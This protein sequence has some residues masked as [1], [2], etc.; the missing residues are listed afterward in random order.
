LNHQVFEESRKLFFNSKVSIMKFLTLFSK[1][2]VVS[3]FIWAFSTTPQPSKIDYKGSFLSLQT[4]KKLPKMDR[5][6]L[7]GLH[8]YEMTKDLQL[9]YPPTERKL[10]AYEELKSRKTRRSLDLRAIPNTTWQE[11]GPNNVGG[12]TRAIM[13]DPNDPEGKRVFAGGVSG[14]LWMNPNIEDVNS[15]WENKDDFMASLAVSSLAF[16]PTTPT[17]FYLATGEGWSHQGLMRGNGIWKSLDGGESWGHLTGTKGTEFTFVNRIAVTA[18]GHIL[19]ATNHGLQ[20]SIDGGATWEVKVPGRA[21]DIAIATNGTIYISVG[22]FSPG[23]IFRS[24]DN[25]QSFQEL[26]GYPT[27]GQRI[28]LAVAPSNPNTLYAV[29]SSNGNIAWFRKSTDGGATWTP[30]AVPRYLNQN[31][32]QSAQDFGR[33]QAWYNLALAVHPENENRVVLGGIDLYKSENGGASWTPIS[34]WTG[35]CKTYVHAD[36]HAIVFHPTRFE[37][38]L[39]GND[40][41]VYRSSDIGTPTESPKFEVRNNGYN[42]TQFYSVAMANSEG[43]HYFLGGTQDNGT[44][45]FASQGV[46]T[47]KMVTGGDGGL[48]FIDQEDPSIQ[49]TSYVYNSY[50][51]STNGGAFFVNRFVDESN[52]GTG[53]FINP[54]DYDSKAKT[55]YAAR[56]ENQMAR[57]SNMAGTRVVNEVLT[58]A[59]GNRR[60]THVKVNPFSPNSLIVANDIG[61]VYKISD[62]HA[63]PIVERIDNHALPAGYVSSVDIGEHEGQLLVTLSNYGVVS[64]WETQNGGLSWDNKEGN[65]PDIPVRW[66]LYNPRNI[67]QVLLATELGIW[68]TDDFSVQSP[69]WEPTLDGLA[70]VRCD[71]LR[72][73]A[74]DGMVAVATHGR[75]LYTTDVFAHQFKADFSVDKTLAYAEQ[76]FYFNDLSFGSEKSWQWEFGDGTTSQEQNPTHH[77]TIAGTYTVKLTIRQGAASVVKEHLIQVLPIKSLDYLT[78]QGGNFEVNTTDF[79]AYTI[80]GTAFQRG[81]SIFPGKSGTTSGQYAWVTGLQGRYAPRTHAMVYTPAFQVNTSGTYQVEFKAIYHLEVEDEQK[82]WDGFVVEYTFDLGNTWNKLGNDLSENWYNYQAHGHNT[83]F[84]SGEAMFSGNTEGEFETKRTQFSIPDQ[85]K[86]VAFRVVFKSDANGEEAGLAIDD[87]QFTLLNANIPVMARI[88]TE[89]PDCNTSEVLFTSHSFGNLKEMRWT[90]GP[91]THLPSL[92]GNGPHKVS[93]TSSGVK[94]ATLWVTDG[95]YTH[96]STLSI[97]VTA[98]RLT[99]VGEELHAS[100]GEAYTWYRNGE[101]I[102]GLH[103]DRLHLSGREE[104]G[105]FQ[106]AVTQAGCTQKSEIITI[107]DEIHI[108]TFPNPTKGMVQIEAR[109]QNGDIKL[110]RVVDRNGR[111][112]Q[113]IHT[114]SFAGIQIDFSNEPKGYY[115]VELNTSQGTITR[116]ILKD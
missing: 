57:Y 71:M 91:D 22:V 105:Y 70:N 51:R 83:A 5:P 66:A 30:L 109:G 101:I 19:A 24:S 11:R 68:S 88:H 35:L 45:Q 21:A 62:A 74:A 16:D 67:R 7:A 113:V 96:E 37:E 48:T 112:V 92:H 40:G 8:D 103:S 29:A 18:L 12:R 38:A 3:L 2:L 55:L 65:L 54:A 73:R 20:I 27:N 10:A 9:G 72:Y 56:N 59:I 100:G 61:Q 63:T 79:A 97:V 85:V 110:S 1:V 28:E 46:N 13:F 23:R 77:Y 6:D 15:K 50:W 41:G 75:G 93:F 106:V 86:N 42:I 84:K 82:A 78:H 32:T 26:A 31:C 44:Q 76:T 34:Y 39:I 108:H 69:D 107:E 14:G 47:T 17:T 58:L 111:P 95:E 81:K 90:F 36:Q 33:G 89:T 116:R 60:L 53:R 80:S 94:T 25:G 104:E 43:A 114:E 49:I 99:R 87:F 98:P 52:Q 115:L 4:V 102:N 64:V